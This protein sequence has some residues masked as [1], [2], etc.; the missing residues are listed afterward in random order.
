MNYT[1][2]VKEKK[3]K[4]EGK[5]SEVIFTPTH[6]HTLSIRL[7]RIIYIEKKIYRQR[8]RERRHGQKAKKRR[9]NHHLGHHKLPPNFLLN[10]P[11][12]HAHAQ[13]QGYLIANKP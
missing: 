2:F 3:K 5:E 11:H 13:A 7:V 6:A 4:N 8:G 9:E 12:A 1:F 10:L